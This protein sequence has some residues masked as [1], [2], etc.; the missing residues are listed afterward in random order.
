[1]AR[2]IFDWVQRGCQSLSDTA[3]LTVPCSW[4]FWVRSP[5]KNNL[6][7]GV[8]RNS[9]DGLG[10]PYPLLLLGSGS[11]P[12]WEAHWANLPQVCENV[13]LQMEHLAIKR[14]SGLEVLRND[15]RLMRPPSGQWGESTSESNAAPAGYEKAHLELNQQLQVQRQAVMLLPILAPQEL[16]PEVQRWHEALASNGAQPPTAVFMGGGLLQTFLVFFAD[17]LGTEDFKLLWA[18]GR[19]TDQAEEK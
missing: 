13:W 4:R 12:G 3:H 1:M 10:R 6:L 17:A 5:Q 14:I 16:L 19:G 18:L 15:L 7:C 11:I 9:C 2:A 8:V